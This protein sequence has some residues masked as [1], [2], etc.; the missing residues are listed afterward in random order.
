MFIIHN[1]FDKNIFILLVFFNLKVFGLSLQQL[2]KQQKN[3]IIGLWLGWALDGYDSVLML[4]VI[5]SINQLFFPSE[6]PSLSL[7]ATFGTYIVTPLMR[8]FGGA[9]FGNF[10]DKY[11]RKK[12]MIITITG[13]SLVTFSTGLLPT[14]QSVGILAPILLVIIRIL[15]GFFAGG[16][17][18]SGAVI[19]MESSP[20]PMRG[21]VSGFVQ[22]G[23]TLGFLLASISFR[24]TNFAFPGDEFMEM[25]WRVLFFTGIIPGLVALF[26]RL[27][28]DESQIWIKEVKEKKIARIPLKNVISNKG[29]RTR[30]FLSL[31][32]TTGLL[33]SYYS[34]SGFMPTLLEKYVN[35]EKHE[36]ANI[37]IVIM[38]FALIG[39]IFAGFISQYIGRLKILTIFG[40]A[41]IIVAIPSLNGI[42]TASNSFE[43]A[44]YSSLLVFFVASGFGT[45]PAFLA[46]RFPTEIR[47]SA[48]GFVYNGGL[49]VGSWAPLITITWL[50]YFD[51]FNI[52][53]YYAVAINIIIGA[54]I[55]IIG[56]KVNPDTRNVDL[57]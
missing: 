28:M 4:F 16:E 53:L 26:V 6:D 39:H 8:P 40:I 49:L 12:A 1:H 43:I 27:K 31:I 3:I 15:Q 35:I 11:G 47:N 10:G 18:G 25:G 14:W 37:M 33:F 48:A 32:L 24:L 41:S 20:K 29:N 13:F 22:S 51:K 34:S 52:P 44:I 54:I 50:S 5:V 45:M 55:V 56:S 7:L 38:I 46:E 21:L 36:V 23:F 17:W 2:T 57:G 19:S 9:F 42:F 30:F